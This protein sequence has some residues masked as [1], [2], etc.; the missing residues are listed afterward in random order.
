L[1]F[2]TP[3]TGIVVPFSGVIGSSPA[4]ADLTTAFNA[5]VTALQAQ[6]TTPVLNRIQQFANGGT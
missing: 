2:F 5:I 3:A 4:Q 6:V 1:Q